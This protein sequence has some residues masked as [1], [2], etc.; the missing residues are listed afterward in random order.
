M[1]YDACFIT[2]QTCCS[3]QQ[4]H[5]IGPDCS[6][7]EKRD[8]RECET[9]RNRLRADDYL[10][11]RR[12][13]PMAATQDIEQLHALFSPFYEGKDILH[14]GSHIRRIACK[15]IDIAAQECIHINHWVVW[16]GAYLHGVVY[17]DD[18]GVRDLLLSSGADSSL[19]DKAVWAAWE[20][21]KE[22]TPNTAEGMVLHDAHLLEGGRTYIVTKCLTTGAARGQSVADTLTLIETDV[23]GA[24]R[25][26]LPSAQQEYAA[27][28][29]YA[30]EYV[31]E[32]KSALE[33]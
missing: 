28:E 27:M 7:D 26:C 25:C 19:V 29:A 6:I 16:C 14:D 18:T 24:Y 8:E 23:L 2:L 20:S 5:R 22:A 21:G 10:P 30:R 1:R 9:A 31:A 11:D 12:F 15:A 13:R 4:R 17:T 3:S 33:R 32:Q